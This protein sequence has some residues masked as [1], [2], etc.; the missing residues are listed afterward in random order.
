MGWV[1]ARACV[2]SM[3]IDEADTY[4]SCA[5]PP[6]PSHWQS[7]LNNHVL[8]SAL[9]RLFTT[10]FGPSHL[11]VRLPALIGAAIYIL[12]AY[13]LCRMIGGHWT[14]EWP[15][16]L[17]LVY[18][19]LVMDFLVA[20]RGYGL[21]TAFLVAVIAIAAHSHRSGPA[22]PPA[23]AL[24]SVCL[25]LSLAA[26]FSFAFVD[27]A[28]LLL[29][30]LWA[31]AGL[32]P[33]RRIREG[34]RLLAACCL[35]GLAVFW[36]L[37][38][39]VLLRWHKGEVILGAASVPEMV[40]SVVT[41]S[42]FQLNPQ[43]ANRIVYKWFHPLGPVLF[44]VLALTLAFVLVL[45]LRQ[46]RALFQDARARWLAALGGLAGGALALTLALHLLALHFFRLPLPKS[47]TAVYFVPLA[48]IVAG[49][50]AAIRVP[51]RLGRIGRTGLLAALFLL[52][53]YHIL[54]LRLTYF[55]EWPWDA[56]VRQAYDVLAYYNH[57]YGARSVAASWPFTA[58]L[59]FYRI[60]SGKE[61]F[62]TFA[63]EPADGLP[64]GRQIYVLLCPNEERCLT[65]YGLKAV[66]RSERG[67]MV[68]AIQPALEAKPCP[69]P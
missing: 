47:R 24:C 67:D 26:N 59:N 35:P 49:T 12:A 3:T 65:R 23:C 2:Q 58:S 32:Q 52:G 46:R 48:M 42:L 56:D 7:S 29:I 11:S 66:Y 34:A 28:S 16:F 61:T 20:A 31:C 50:A 21:A 36:F 14:L 53:A 25:A 22:S 54:C 69:V 10:V 5:A 64:P 15:L 30:C 18:N 9:M 1:V 8:N 27:A 41:A 63:P 57:A 43:V 33:G 19:P 44:P 4:L 55:Y 37:S 60:A 62:S 6:D 45:I 17:C 51:S 40:G 38:L 39:S 13:W 68:V